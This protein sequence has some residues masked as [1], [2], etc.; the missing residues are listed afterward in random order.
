MG[1]ALLTYHIAD[2]CQEDSLHDH[3]KWYGICQAIASGSIST[4]SVS[5]VVVG[6]FVYECGRHFKKQG[7]LTHH[8]HFSDC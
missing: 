2:T 6:S 8:N 5:T 3:A 4:A 1:V 7:D